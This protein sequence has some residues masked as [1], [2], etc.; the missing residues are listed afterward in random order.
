MMMAL[1]L[2]VFALETAPYQEFQQQIGWRHPS[3]NRVGRRASRQYTGLDDETVTL[4]GV[5]LP[6][7]SGGDNTIDHLRQMGDTGQPYVLIE[8][9]G[10]YYG[11]FE[12][13]SLSVTRSLFFPDGKARRIEFTLNLTRVDE[14]HEPLANEPAQP[15]APDV[16]PIH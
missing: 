8:G 1:G 14:I 15:G 3:N 13:D 11:M 10:R 9:S 16:R 4:S 12:I 2:F 6:E 5:L 7:L